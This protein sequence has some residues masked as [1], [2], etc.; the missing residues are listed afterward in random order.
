VTRFLVVV[1]LALA[2]T[3]AFAQ[4][5][6]TPHVGL[7]L[8]ETEDG[9]GVLGLTGSFAL[10]PDRRITAL[11]SAQNAE[12]PNR[13]VLPDDRLELTVHYFHAGGVYRPVKQRGAQGFVMATGGVTW[14][15]PRD[16]SFDSGAGFSLM[17]GGGVVVPL[18]ERLKLRFDGRG[19]ATLN[20]IS[21]AGICG[22]VGCSVRVSTGGFF[23]VEA[24]VGLTIGF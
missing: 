17:F 21:V 14:V 5:E 1:A 4:V 20:D 15:D 11:W 18:G 22:G 23:Q 8:G 12:V 9:G 24:L 10:Q 2:P 16:A 7:R 6:L 19:Y 3:L 13:I